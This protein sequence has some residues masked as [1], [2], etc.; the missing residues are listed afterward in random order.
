VKYLVHQLQIKQKHIINPYR[1]VAVRA[2]VTRRIIN[3]NLA[4]TYPQN[5]AQCCKNVLSA[6]Y[7]FIASLLKGIETAVRK[8]VF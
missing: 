4:P 5:G 8:G 3:P 2:L 7:S 1:T 6:W